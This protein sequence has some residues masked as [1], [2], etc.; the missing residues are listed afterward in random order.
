[1]DGNDPYALSATW[2]TP[3]NET[4]QGIAFFAGATGLHLKGV[5]GWEISDHFSAGITFQMLNV[6]NPANF[7]KADI[8]S[9]GG[10]FRVNFSS[11]QNQWIP[12]FQGAFYFSN[13]QKYTQDQATNGSQTQPAISASGTTSIGFNADLG[14]EYLVTK[15]IGVQLT[16]GFSGL[17]P[18]DE[19]PAGV[20]YSPYYTPVHFNGGFYFS[21]CGG[22]KYYFGR[23]GKKR[24]F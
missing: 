11:S 21:V 14:L 8:T 4:E 7:R 6:S 18:I 22:I 3:G 10:Q 5:L 17:Q 24:D 15:S 23:G 20:S 19:V 13:S 1:M 16:A 2:P 9:I 12:F